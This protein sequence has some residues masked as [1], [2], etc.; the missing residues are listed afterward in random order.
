MWPG[1]QFLHRGRSLANEK[2]GCAWPGPQFLY[3]ENTSPWL[4]FSYEKEHHPHLS[5]RETE[6]LTE[7][8]DLNLEKSAWSWW[9][10]RVLLV[11][12]PWEG[13]APWYGWPALGPQGHTKWFCF[14]SVNVTPLATASL[15]CGASAYPAPSCIQVTWHPRDIQ[16]E[17]RLLC[18]CRQVS[19]PCIPQPSFWLLAPQLHV[20]EVCG[21][22]F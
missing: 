11:E 21:L 13:K 14:F 16:P 10:P 7:L 3:R 9:F 8:W 5:G 20:M 12:R 17:A 18:S 1:P 6:A 19:S 2:A 22:A 4:K 15:P